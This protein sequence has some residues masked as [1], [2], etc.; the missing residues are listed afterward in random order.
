MISKGDFIELDFIAMADGEIFDTTD[1]QIA[2]QIGYK[3]EVRPIKIIVGEGMVVKGLDKNLEGK[4]IGKE[5]EISLSPEEAF[6]KRE[7]RLIKTVPI[8]VFG[9]KNVLKENSFISIEGI[10]A[11]ILK[12]GSGRVILDF[13]HPLAGKTITYKFKIKRKIEDEEEKIKTILS[14]FGIKDYKIEKNEKFKLIAELPE[15]ATELIKR[16]TNCVFEKKE[17]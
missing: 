15:K 10:V 7:T 14:F 6:G 11:K 8:S 5:Y 1:T 9:N 4:E 13:N 12:V 17:K 16:Y 2:R 3:G